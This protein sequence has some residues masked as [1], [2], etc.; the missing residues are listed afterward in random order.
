MVKMHLREMGCEYTA[1][2]QNFTSEAPESQGI[3]I[4]VQ[5]QNVNFTIGNS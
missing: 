1:V 5:W 2:F 4:Y 3:L